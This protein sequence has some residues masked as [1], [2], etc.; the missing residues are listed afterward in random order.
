MLIVSYP[1]V[2]VMEGRAL[3][4]STPP[5][6]FTA[7]AA[8]SDAYT[9]VFSGFVCFVCSRKS[10]DSWQACHWQA[11]HCQVV[12]PHMPIPDSVYARASSWPMPHHRCPSLHLQ[13]HGN[14]D[15]QN[16][17]NIPDCNI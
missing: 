15:D 5:P 11:Q 9:L 2:M 17:R 1:G 8:K 7:G 13:G 14:H 4:R 16:L 6:P 12:P 3:N 10:L